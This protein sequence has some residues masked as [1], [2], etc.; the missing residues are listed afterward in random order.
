MLIP[1]PMR[2]LLCAA[3]AAACGAPPATTPVPPPA[4]PRAADSAAAPAPVPPARRE[5]I[6]LS[7]YGW[8]HGSHAVEPIVIITPGGL[9]DPAGLDLAEFHARYYGRGTRYAVRVGGAPAGEALATK[10][11]P[12]SCFPRIGLARV[13]LTGPRPERWSGLASDVFGAAPDQ[14]LFRPAA[15]EQQAVLARLADSILTA[16]GLP[17]EQ[18]AS[19]RRN[20]RF[21]VRAH[22]FEGPVLVGTFTIRTPAVK[23]RTTWTLALIAERHG[24]FYRPVYVFQAQDDSEIAAHV[25][26]DA[27]DL[28][29][30][31]VPELVMQGR[32]GAGSWGYGIL[33]RRADGWTRI[34]FGARRGC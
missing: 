8:E 19:T 20:E 21:A 30:D 18:R 4:A 14:P 16:R 28:D 3:L 24:G 33:Q 6:L 26:S 10:T 13:T 27:V 5:G 34:Y 25:F 17:P 23:P 31:R 15:Q 1:R 7:V 9:R 22:G 11:R 2:L 12:N 29:G 32:D